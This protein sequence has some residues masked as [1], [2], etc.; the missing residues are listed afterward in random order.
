MTVQHIFSV[1]G[2]P[3]FPVG[4]Q[5]HNSSGYNMKRDG[6]GLEGSGGYPR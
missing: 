4:G 1:H 5:T 2:Q 3:F 6:L